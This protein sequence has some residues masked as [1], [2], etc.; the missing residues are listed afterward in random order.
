MT[1]ANMRADARPSTG[2]HIKDA[3]LPAECIAIMLT[4]MIVSGE[5]E[6]DIWVTQ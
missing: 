5:L 3:Q 2:M 1:V 4:E 6:K